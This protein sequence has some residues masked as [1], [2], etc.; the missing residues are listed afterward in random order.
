MDAMKGCLRGR[1]MGGAV[2]PTVSPG[3]PSQGPCRPGGSQ[4]LTREAAPRLLSRL[5]CD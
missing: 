2:G 4:P 3:F 5:M 1:E